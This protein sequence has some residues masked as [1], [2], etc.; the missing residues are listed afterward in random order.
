MSSL[1]A[2]RERTAVEIGFAS[3]GVAIVLERLGFV[4]ASV[5]EL[6][7]SLVAALAELRSDLSAGI[8]ATSAA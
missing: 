5:A 7:W 3:L 8:V 4:D 1:F 6:G 2:P